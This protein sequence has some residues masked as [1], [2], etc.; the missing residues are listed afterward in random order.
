MMEKHEIKKLKNEFI[1][2]KKK[3]IRFVN[4]E[5]GPRLWYLPKK[6]LV[7]ARKYGQYFGPLFQKSLKHL[8]I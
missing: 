8:T 6:P 5:I 3:F 2:W 4:V 1:F 7:N